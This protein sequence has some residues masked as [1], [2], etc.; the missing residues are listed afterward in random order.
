M[1]DQELETYSGSC[2]CGACKFS[3][4]LPELKQVFACNCSICSKVLLVTFSL[5][6]QTYPWRADSTCSQKGYLWALP[7]S[8]DL[9]V[10][11]TADGVLKDYLFGNK[12]MTHKVRLM[13]SYSTSCLAR[14]E[15]MLMQLKFCPTCGTAVM[16]QRHKDSPSIG[17]NVRKKHFHHTHRSEPGM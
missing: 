9:F 11:E 2:H 6:A 3:V 12:T 16:G 17:V 4:K 10:L 13:Y 15:A 1:A 7:S 8:D 14:T 5:F